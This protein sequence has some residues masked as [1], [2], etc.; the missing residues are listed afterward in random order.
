VRN[1]LPKFQTCTK[2]LKL[3][4]RYF[5]QISQETSKSVLSADLL[6]SSIYIED[7]QKAA[8]EGL[9]NIDFENSYMFHTAFIHGHAHWPPLSLSTENPDSKSEDRKFY[10]SVQPAVFDGP[11]VWPKEVHE[12]VEKCLVRIA[13]A[14]KAYGETAPELKANL[15]NG[16]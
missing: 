15:T 4:P 7:L 14:M 8:A 6:T 13:P 10:G 3:K 2:S 16:A 1:Y 11:R 9:L 12:L 5:N